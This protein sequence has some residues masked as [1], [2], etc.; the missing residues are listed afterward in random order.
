[1]TLEWFGERVAGRFAGDE[2][3]RQRRRHHRTVDDPWEIGA[4]YRRFPAW[5]EMPVQGV[6]GIAMDAQR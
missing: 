2:R 6:C 4:W 3:D 5:P 1:V